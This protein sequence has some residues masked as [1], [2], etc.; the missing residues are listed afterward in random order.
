MVSVR[1]A[2]RLTRVGACDAPVVVG[3]ITGAGGAHTCSAT[4]SAFSPDPSGDSSIRFASF[5]CPV[6]VGIGVGKRAPTGRRVA[7]GADARE[8]RGEHSGLIRHAGKLGQQIPAVKHPVQ[9]MQT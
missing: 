8:D 7:L 6:R 9:K 1:D 2:S 5:A 4:A 3:R